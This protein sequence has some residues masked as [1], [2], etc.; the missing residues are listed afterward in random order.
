MYGPGRQP[1]L[2]TSASRKERASLGN[3]SHMLPIAAPFRS[4]TRASTICR[5]TWSTMIGPSTSG[6]GQQATCSTRIVPSTCGAGQRVT[7]ST[8]TGSSTRGAGQQVS[9]KGTE[10]PPGAPSGRQWNKFA[11]DTGSKCG[12]N[13]AGSRPLA[14]IILWKM[15]QAGNLI[16]LPH[17]SLCQ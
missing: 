2:F 14:L 10:Q 17:P 1:R 9:I 11:H 3:C 15:N 7:W 8:R 12:D 4:K 16:S 13:T 5:A 6:A